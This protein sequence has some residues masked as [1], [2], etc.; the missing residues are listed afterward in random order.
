MGANKLGYLEGL[1]GV[2]ALAVLGHHFMLAMYP[3]A[4]D[5]NPIRFHTTG[6]ESWWY[7]SPLNVL[8][9]GN[10]CVTIFF[11]LSGM[12]LSRSYLQKN[13]FGIIIS[14]A[15]RRFL[16]LFIPVGFVIILS[17][18]MLNLDAYKH[19]EVAKISGSDWWLATSWNVDD[20]FSTFLAYFTYKVMFLGLPDYDTSMWTMSMELFGSFGVF[21]ILAGVY[22]IKRRY[23]VYLVAMIIILALGYNDLKSAPSTL[24]FYYLAFVLGMMLNDFP[25][26]NIKKQGPLV[27]YVLVPI[28]FFG[29]LL[30]GSFPSL[31]WSHYSWWEFVEKQEILNRYDVIH[32]IGSM[33]LVSAIVLSSI[34]QK[35]LSIKPI[36]FLGTVS[37]SLYLLHP[38]VMSALAFPI[39]L[40]LHETQGYNMAALISLLA[41]VLSTVLLSW[42]M[43][44]TV[45]KFSITFTK[46][47]LGGSPVAL[48][49]KE[50]KKKKGT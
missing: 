9:N 45:D 31:A 27:S 8:T 22:F 20:S 32:V 34:L 7:G 14:S 18:I 39:F 47:Y 43:A 50:K 6:L 21:A 17:F 13:D 41:L 11:V 42:G 23:I 38:L 28:L 29:G 16:R 46:K 12:V 19:M 15:K 35:I 10:F 48:K 40:S 4:Y 30:L 25:D 49:V 36:I 26:V 33:L 37:F 2:A 5:S 24:K 1:R 44:I 3:G